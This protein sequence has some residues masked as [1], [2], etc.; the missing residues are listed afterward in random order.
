MAFSLYK[1][2]F[3]TIKER[4]KIIFRKYRI[5]RRFVVFSLNIAGLI[6]IKQA[7]TLSLDPKVAL[8]LRAKA[9]LRATC[10]SGA[11]LTAFIARTTS[12]P[13]LE[14]KSI[15]WCGLFN[16]G[17]I[18]GNGPFDRGLIFFLI[19]IVRVNPF[20]ELVEESLSPEITAEETNSQDTK[21]EE[22][23]LEEEKKE[24][25]SPENN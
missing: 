13:P 15:C 3:Q 17:Y 5:C 25:I 20:E 1:R 8:F 23:K 18:L 16:I 19:S 2:K 14:L 9:T 7:Y 21:E 10:C 24:E 12:S 4:V 6:E 11:L 22:K